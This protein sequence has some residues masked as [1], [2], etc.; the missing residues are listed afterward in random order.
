MGRKTSSP[1][2]PSSTTSLLASPAGTRVTIQP[3]VERLIAVGYGL[4]YDAI[5]RGFAPYEAL[6]EEVGSFVARG[7]RPGPPVGTR[8]LDVSCGVGSVAS[9]L[10]RRGWTVAGLDAVAHLVEVARRRHGGT[11]LSLTFHHAD[12]A[13]EPL[14]DRRRVRCPGQHAHALLAS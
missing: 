1:V 12:V 5:V 11:R 2:V 4:T 7:A 8:V 10:A 6:I 13:R 9:R 14:P 3:A